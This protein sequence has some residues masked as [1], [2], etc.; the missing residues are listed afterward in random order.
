MGQISLLGGLD[1][2]K[3]DN[4]LYPKYQSLLLISMNPKGL[5]GLT[6]LGY[7]QCIQLAFALSMYI[8]GIEIHSIYFH[9][10]FSLWC[11]KSPSIRIFL[12]REKTQSALFLLMIIKFVPT[13]VIVILKIT[14]PS[15]YTSVFTAEVEND[16]RLLS[17][18]SLCQSSSFFIFRQFSM[19][20]I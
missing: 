3:H 5:H 10:I 6:V 11:S 14:Y 8:F 20:P 18:V 1:Y 4:D 2:F 17:A 12:F 19:C 7:I 13:F 16:W 9:S 15:K